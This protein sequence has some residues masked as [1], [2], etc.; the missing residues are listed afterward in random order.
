MRLPG[1]VLVLALVTF[2]VYAPVLRHGFVEWDDPY[3]VTE[4]A[5]VRSGLSAGGIAWALRSTELANW[6][7]LTWLS[8]MLDVSL[9]GLAPWG[10]HLTSLLLHLTNV[11]LLFAALRSSVSWRAMPCVTSENTGVK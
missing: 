3:Y 7:P 11:V 2:A 1:A 5:H 10:H 4:N 9:F 8:H 6:H